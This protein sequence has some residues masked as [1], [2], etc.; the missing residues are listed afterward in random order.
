MKEFWLN[1]EGRLEEGLYSGPNQTEFTHKGTV[2]EVVEILQRGCVAV[3]VSTFPFSS[4]EK[5]LEELSSISE[6]SIPN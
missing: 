4:V 5:A 6:S 2:E 3:T 1:L